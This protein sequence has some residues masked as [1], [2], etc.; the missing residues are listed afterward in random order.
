MLV[1]GRY[2]RCGCV[3][4][5]NSSVAGSASECERAGSVLDHFSAVIDPPKDV[6]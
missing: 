6:A 3:L 2:V 5:S 4:W 1:L